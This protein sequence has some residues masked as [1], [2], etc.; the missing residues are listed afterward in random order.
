MWK[1]KWLFLG[2]YRPPSQCE[3]YFFDQ[4]EQ[5]LD[6][7][8]NKY[9]NIVIMGDFNFE[10]SETVIS[11]FMDHYNLSSIVKNPTCFKSASPRC[12]DLILTSRKNNFQHTSTIETGLSDLLQENLLFRF[13]LLLRALVNRAL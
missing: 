6:N 7:F 8:N 10:I 12:I 3:Q 11:D 5:G 1:Q 2:I 4:I 9:K 13:G